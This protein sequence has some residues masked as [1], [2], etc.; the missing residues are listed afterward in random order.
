VE[1]EKGHASWV[2]VA[3]RLAAKHDVG[4]MVVFKGG[5]GEGGIYWG[6]WREEG[7]RRML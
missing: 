5:R 1:Q 4:L 7:G 6:R 2:V 3:E